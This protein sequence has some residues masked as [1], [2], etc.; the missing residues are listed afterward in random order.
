MPG[1]PVYQDDNS[2][3]PPHTVVWADR[4][5]AIAFDYTTSEM[6]TAESK[7]NQITAEQKAMSDCS[8]HGAQN[9]KI[10]V[11]YKNEC[12]AL[13]ASNNRIGFTQSP[14][15]KRAETIAVKQCGDTISCQII[16][17]ACSFPIR[18]Q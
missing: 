4:W 10:I 17:S 9:C 15:Q 13:A 5:G 18:I 8:S 7:N 3:S 1:S 14:K 16:Y 2:T 6:G 11:S 12:V